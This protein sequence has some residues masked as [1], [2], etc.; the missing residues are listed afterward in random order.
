MTPPSFP[1]ACLP[2]LPI[3]VRSSPELNP[4]VAF[5]RLP[6]A[7]H[8]SPIS[9]MDRNSFLLS[10]KMI[11]TH[12]KVHT[13]RKSHDKK[14][15]PIRHGVSDRLWAGKLC[16]HA[17]D[18]SEPLVLRDVPFSSGV[19]AEVGRSPHPGTASPPAAHQGPRGPRPSEAE[20]TPQSPRPQGMSLRADA[21]S[22][23]PVVARC[24]RAQ[25]HFSPPECDG[26]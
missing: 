20:L 12:G 10:A 8:L 14:W 24:R 26:K 18:D 15:R 21:R 25:R 1:G 6:L 11:D 5:A 7:S 22:P 2:H 3:T 16:H 23:V 4:C 17:G 19:A 13:A 9:L